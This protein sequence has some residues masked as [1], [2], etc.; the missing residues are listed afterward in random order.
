MKPA[1][2]F[3]IGIFFMACASK[4]AQEIAFPTVCKAEDDHK[5]YSITG[6]LTDGGSVFCS[7]IGGGRME[8]SF[9]LSERPD[10]GAKIGAEIAQ[11]SSANSVEEFGSSYKKEELKI[12]DNSGGLV[13]I[14]DKVKL[15]GEYQALPDGSHCSLEVDKIERQ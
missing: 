4:Q 10:G 11:G 15:T 2:I 9:S 1:L 6:Y 7:N 12:H 3:V 8:C 14:G 13:K 5:Y